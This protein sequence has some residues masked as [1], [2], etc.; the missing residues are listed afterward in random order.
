MPHII[1]HISYATYHMPHIICHI[2]Y[3]TYHMS[4]HMIH[5]MIKS[6]FSDK[7]FNVKQCLMLK[8]LLKFVCLSLK[9]TVLTV[10]N[11]VNKMANI[12]E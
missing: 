12:L 1:C 10:E 8:Y 4:Y 6:L 9:T 11:K 2:S 7:P 5:V 3:A